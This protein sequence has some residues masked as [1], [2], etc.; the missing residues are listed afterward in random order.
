MLDYCLPQTS[1]LSNDLQEWKA[2]KD[3]AIAMEEA[4]ELAEAQHKQVSVII[5][6]GVVDI[7]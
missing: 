2:A 1:E 5:M 4:A 3:Q 7:A 6:T